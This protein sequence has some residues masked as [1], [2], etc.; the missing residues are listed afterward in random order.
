M[1]AVFSAAAESPAFPA[2]G[3]YRE[4]FGGIWA[5]RSRSAKTDIYVSTPRIKNLCRLSK[6]SF[7]K[8]KNSVMAASQGLCHEE[9]TALE[10]VPQTDS[11]F[12]LTTGHVIP[13]R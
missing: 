7:F 12:S 11:S 1:S 9:T 8:N 4:Y 2:S 13:L 5:Q 3:G 10:E 6:R